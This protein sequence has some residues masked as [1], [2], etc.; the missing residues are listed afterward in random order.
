M[1]TEEKYRRAV[2]ALQAIATREGYTHKTPWQDEWT[3][4]AAFSD[5]KETAIRCLK[6]LGE[7]T[8]L[9]K[10]T[11]KEELR[12]TI[13]IGTPQIFRCATCGQPTEI[14]GI[15]TECADKVEEILPQI[16][17]EI[18]AEFYNEPLTPSLTEKVK[19][20]AKDLILAATGV[21]TDIAVKVEMCGISITINPPKERRNPQ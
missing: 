5:C 3:E 18:L 10:R 12:M 15:C 16:Y 11:K 21:K 1:T 17:N 19:H 4:A 2:L 20:R 7:N 13:E 6:L 14:E 8:S 9:P